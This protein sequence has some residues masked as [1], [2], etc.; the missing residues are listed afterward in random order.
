M[1]TGHAG[2]QL[3]AAQGVARQPPTTFDNF[4]PVSGPGIVIQVISAG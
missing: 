4:P 2:V 3:V 1:S